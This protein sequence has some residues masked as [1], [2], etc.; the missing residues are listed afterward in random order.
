M[1]LTE[2]PLHPSPE[3][4]AQGEAPGAEPSSYLT[5]VKRPG[6]CK[7]NTVLALHKRAAVCVGCPT[8]L[9][10]ATGGKARLTEDAP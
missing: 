1:P 4:E 9:C 2:N 7:V 5:A 6:R 10:Q 8:V 3:E